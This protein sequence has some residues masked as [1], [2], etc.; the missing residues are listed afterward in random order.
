AASDAAS[1]RQVRRNGATGGGT[2]AAMAAMSS[3]GITPGPLGISDTSPSADAPAAIAERASAGL[4]IQQTLTRG[5]RVGST[6]RGSGHGGTAS[7]GEELLAQAVEL[8]VELHDLQLGLEVHLVVQLAA[9]AVFRVR[10]VL[11]HHDHGRLQRGDHG[12]EQ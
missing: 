6:A 12:E 3:A 7:R 2:A 11:A 4:W 9:D 8:L 10:P 1:W 5:T